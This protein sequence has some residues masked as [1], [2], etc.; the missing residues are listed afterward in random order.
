MSWVYKC[1]PFIFLV[2][3][4]GQSE[5]NLQSQGGHTLFDSRPGVVYAY[6]DSQGIAFA[7]PDSRMTR[8]DSEK[9][10]KSKAAGRCRKLFTDIYLRVTLIT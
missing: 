2:S 10:K 8:K 7:F 3:G 9:K 4:S 6:W 5:F 1:L